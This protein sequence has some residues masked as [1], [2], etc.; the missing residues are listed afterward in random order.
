M[1][2]FLT[3]LFLLAGNSDALQCLTNCSLGKYR[4]NTPLVADNKEC[5]QRVSA[6]KCSVNVEFFYHSKT[7]EVTH[8]YNSNSRDFI[9]ITMQPTLSYDIRITTMTSQYYDIS[10][11]HAQLAPLIEN[12]STSNSIQCYNMKNAIVLC[13]PREVCNVDYNPRDHRARS[14]GCKYL[15]IPVVMVYDS[16]TYTS[17][18]ITCNR[19][20][21]NGDTTLSEVKRILAEHGLTDSSGRR[22]A[23]GT[24]EMASVFLLLITSIFVLSFYF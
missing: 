16:E 15:S 10:R 9:Y 11:L 22:I 8:E 18:D 5:Q 14:R 13:A 6:S 7:Y 21:C 17:F 24:K 20:L 19:N 2:V 4:F 12:S 1:L 3:V 23:A